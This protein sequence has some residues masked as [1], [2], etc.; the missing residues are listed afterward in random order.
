VP[1]DNVVHVNLSG[2]RT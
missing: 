1:V 2:W